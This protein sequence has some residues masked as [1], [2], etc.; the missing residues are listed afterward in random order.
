MPASASRNL[1]H[2]W[3]RHDSCIETHPI[4]TRNRSD[5]RHWGTFRTWMVEPTMSLH[6]GKADLTAARA[7]FRKWPT[8]FGPLGWV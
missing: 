6:R 1:M 7:D 8:L 5:F 4:T 2:R 3:N